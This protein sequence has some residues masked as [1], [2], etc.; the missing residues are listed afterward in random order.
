MEFFIAIYIGIGVGI[1]LFTNKARLK[2]H[3]A[4]MFIL[5]PFYWAWC[6]MCAL[7]WPIDL[8]FYVLEKKKNNANS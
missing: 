6:S 5:S 1:S 8:M 4:E 2:E 7:I 3:D